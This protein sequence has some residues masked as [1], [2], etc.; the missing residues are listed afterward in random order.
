MFETGDELSLRRLEPSSD[1]VTFRTGGMQGLFT[2]LQEW[3]GDVKTR[4]C[5][6]ALKGW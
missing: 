5:L 2:H 3:V 1:D 6:Q 4:I